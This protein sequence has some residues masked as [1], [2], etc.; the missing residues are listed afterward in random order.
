MFEK[1]SQNTFG[2][3][4]GILFSMLIQP[5]VG[6][7][8][9]MR[10]FGF[11]EGLKGSFVS[12][13][14]QN[15][16]GFLVVAT[17]EGVSNFD[18]TDFFISQFNDSTGQTYATCLQNDN[19][20]R[21]T[22]GLNTGFVVSEGRQGYDTLFT[23]D[24]SSRIVELFN[25]SN[26]SLL[27]I[28]AAFN[29]FEIIDNGKTRMIPLLD[30]EGVFSIPSC[31]NVIGDKIIVG[32]NEGVYIWSYS[33]EEESA[34]FVSFLPELEFVNITSIEIIDSSSLFIGTEDMG[35]WKLS[36]SDEPK[37]EHQN[38][39]ARLANLSVTDML[40]LNGEYL[41][42]G[43]KF[44]GIYYID[45]NK[46]KTI[47]H[48]SF[49][50]HLSDV[51]TSQQVSCLYPDK[52]G[53]IWVGSPGIGISQ[54][55]ISPFEFFG[56]NRLGS[57]ITHGITSFQD[58]QM[59]L[60]TD[61]GLVEVTLFIEYDS[62]SFRVVEGTEELD[63]SAIKGLNDSLIII[64][65]STGKIYYYSALGLKQIEIG[66]YLSGHKIEYVNVDL[67]GNIWVIIE[68]FG[69]LS[70]YP[71]GELKRKYDIP[72][73][74]ITN[75]IKFIHF[76]ENGDILFGTHVG[77]LVRENKKGELFFLSREEKFPF[78]DINN[79]FSYSRDTTLI[80]T[81]GSGLF[82]IQNDSMY[83][84]TQMEGLY[85]NYIV[86]IEV[87]NEGSIWTLHRK[88][89]SK[90]SVKDNKVI[91]FGKRE[92][93]SNSRAVLNSISKDKY[94][95][96]WIGHREGVTWFHSPEKN[97]FV[98]E[99]PTY[100]T[101]ISVGYKTL[102]NVKPEASLNPINPQVISFKHNENNI[103]F[104]FACVSLMFP[105]RMKYQYELEGNDLKMSLKT[106]INQ[107]FYNNLPP[108]DYKFKVSTFYNDVLWNLNPIEFQFRINQPFWE[109]WWF[110]LIQ[111][112]I[113]GILA[114]F[115]IVYGVREYTIYTRILVYVTLFVLFDIAEILVENN[116]HAFKGSAPVFQVLLHLIL[117]L[118]L[119]PIESFVRGYFKK[120]TKERAGVGSVKSQAD[121]S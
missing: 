82:V 67:K 81:S 38:K 113:L 120:K 45:L 22:I 23:A 53:S 19:L 91:A 47:D 39:I 90:L 92:G 6:Q 5:L 35:V 68:G 114:F 110:Y 55:I 8:Y 100:F 34:E 31:M 58:N 29:L 12:K 4:L 43:T 116:V 88:G 28:D 52:E 57:G 77:G 33:L 37:V 15:K 27:G 94:G 36:L 32:T 64:G 76:D 102:A 2:L 119:F 63:V 84:I 18:G 85:D 60:A 71:N 42:V 112:L 105:G 72:N 106:H 118:F 51:L 70:F 13:I 44:D 108:G 48:Q 41:C 74:F 17:E 59:F 30:V 97:F 62:C 49:V 14:L 54:L 86:G 21:L 121:E 73:G 25:Y 10:T 101:Q 26:N 16:H 9:E 61:S 24:S 56:P 96:I 107:A 117:A 111:F 20:G 65:T 80:G 87:D 99:L 95:H 78:V 115:T 7:Q 66:D 83:S 3:L 50:R 46:N 104:D 79:I 69:A 98:T 103:S 89:I 93:F 75:D 11:D 40:Y 109:T 1:L